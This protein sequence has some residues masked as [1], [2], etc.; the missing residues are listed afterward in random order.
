MSFFKQA[1]SNAGKLSDKL[2]GP[3]YDY[4]G[5]VKG[6]G[7][8]GMSDQGTLEAL[9]ND[10]KGLIGYADILVMGGGRASRVKGPLGNK[11]FLKSG[12]KCKDTKSGKDVDRYIYINNVPSQ[13][14]GGL[15][16]G[17]TTGVDSLNPFRLMGAFSAGSEPK[18]RP[19]SLE[20]VDNNNSRRRETHYM[21][22]NDIKYLRQGFS[23]MDEEEDLEDTS[24]NA[25]L[26]EDHY[27]Q[28]YYVFLATFG[29]YVIYK[30][31]GKK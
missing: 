27:I 8:M 31:M 26:P 30:M 13:P 16:K 5:K 24:D 7:S 1:Q 28:A 23:N 14:F 21:T 17:T 20:V 9:G 29:V 3:P 2:L 22:L 18:C 15:I 4:K 6:P 25:R 11:F 10:V 19:I 12:M